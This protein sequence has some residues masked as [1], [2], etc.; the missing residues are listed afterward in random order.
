ML[1]EVMKD[2]Q[3]VACND[4]TCCIYDDA[5]FRDIQSAGFTFRLNGKKATIKD[6]K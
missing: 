2:D 3:I 1:F 6:I 4:Q 5:Q